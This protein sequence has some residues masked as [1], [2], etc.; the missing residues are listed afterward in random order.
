MSAVTLRRPRAGLAVIAAMATV[1]I[2]WGSTYLAIRVMVETIPPVLAGALRFLVAGAL[3][4]AILAALGRWAMPSRRE[5]AG[6]SIFGC[7]ILIGGVGGVTL[8][9]T[10]IPSN[11]A[12]VIA[13]MA[14]LWVIVFRVLARERVGRAVLGGALVGFAGVALLLLPAADATGASLTWL[15]GSLAFPIFWSSGSFY[16]PKVLA[17]PSDPFVASA[18]EM[19]AAGAVQ[20]VIAVAIGDLGET[21][22][23]SISWRSAAAIAYLMLASIVAF[24]AYVWLLDRMPISTV[25]THQFVNPA[26]AVLLGWL[27]LSETLTPL[28]LGAMAIIIGAVALIVRAAPASEA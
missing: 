7:W 15:V 13:S 1:Y 6:A 14:A 10:R 21:H 22:A 26:V 20:L 25:F 8:A 3:L 28:M 24:S 23:S 12:A 17:L 9:E 2:V 16:G 5:L 4:V 27:V 19:V 11:V 18:V